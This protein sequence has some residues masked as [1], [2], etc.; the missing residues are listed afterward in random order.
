MNKQTGP[1]KEAETIDDEDVKRITG[2]LFGAATDTTGSTLTTFL[3]CMV[4]NPEVFKKAQEEIDRVIGNDRLIDYDDKDS[5]PYFA[6]VLKEVLRWGCPVPL[7][8]PHR[9]VEEDNYRGY[10]IPEG[11]TIIANS[12]AM[13][14]DGAVYPSPN[15]FDPERFF[16]PEKMASEACQQVEA[17]FGFGRRTCPGRFFAEANMWMLMTNLIA[18]MDIG[19]AVDEKGREIDVTAEYVGSLVRHLQSFKCK[20]GYRSEKARAVVEQA[21]LLHN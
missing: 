9:L 8:I 19:K 20:V 18:T 16:G 17:V 14:R 7:G 5:L 2:V 6:A 13:T 1:Y 3:F 12:W 11:T 10:V 15:A 21:N 4:K